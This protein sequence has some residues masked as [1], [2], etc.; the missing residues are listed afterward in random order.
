MSDIVPLS[1]STFKRTADGWVFAPSAAVV[2]PW[3]ASR[4]G[5]HYLVDDARKDELALAIEG[6][7]R[8]HRG[9]CMVFAVFCGLIAV[10]MLGLLIA[11][12]TLPVLPQ[13]PPMPVFA[14]GG[15]IFLAVALLPFAVI[16]GWYAFATRRILAGSPRTSGRI[17]YEEYLTKEAATLT[18]KQIKLQLGVSLMFVGLFVGQLSQ[19]IA[20]RGISAWIFW[21][22]LLM[23]VGF[24]SVHWFKVMKVK[25]AMDTAAAAN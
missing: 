12:L 6:M 7:Q 5:S 3:L 8:A 14:D 24:T 15:T 23:I 20:V 18:M 10:A 16:V 11:Y 9:V 22:G 1:E 13:L 4:F 21:A 2:G 25:R 17:S 19:A